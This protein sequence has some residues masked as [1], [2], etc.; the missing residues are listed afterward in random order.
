MPD[1][2]KEQRLLK[3]LRTRANWHRHVVVTTQYVG[4]DLVSRFKQEATGAAIVRRLRD[5]LCD[6]IHARRADQGT[7]TTGTDGRKEFRI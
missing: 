2:K 4:A 6:S 5:P 3:L 1:F 7:V